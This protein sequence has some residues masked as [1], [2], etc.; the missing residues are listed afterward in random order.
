MRPISKFLILL[1]FSTSLS[2][3]YVN[4]QNELFNLSYEIGQDQFVISSLLDKNDILTYNTYRLKSPNSLKEALLAG[5]ILLSSPEKDQIIYLADTAET[6]P[7]RAADVRGLLGSLSFSR[8]AEAD[9]L[10]N[11]KS[12]R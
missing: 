5:N 8:R 9:S 6:Q 10:K 4:Q 12:N 7:A 1:V 11:T 3:Y 2:L